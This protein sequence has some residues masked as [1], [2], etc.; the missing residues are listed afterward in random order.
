[1]IDIPTDTVV[2]SLLIELRSIPTYYCLI[3]EVELDDGLP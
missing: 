1:M 2:H 3:D